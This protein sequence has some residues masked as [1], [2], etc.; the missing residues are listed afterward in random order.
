MSNLS[1]NEIVGFQVESTAKWR[2][3]KAE[4]FP[5]D[6]RN[7]KAADELERL[8]GEID[9]LE[10]SELHLSIDGII[11]KVGDFDSDLFIKHNEIVSEELRTVGFHGSYE[12]GAAFLEWY[13]DS[14]KTLLEERIDNEFVDDEAGENQDHPLSAG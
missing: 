6:L 12:N 8:A 14:L 7:L 11:S 2:R 3:E 4:Q 1:I 10:G 9:Q 5:D 13:R